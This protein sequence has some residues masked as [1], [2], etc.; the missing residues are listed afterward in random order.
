VKSTLVRA[1]N[2]VRWIFTPRIHAA[3]ITMTTNQRRPLD[4]SVHIHQNLAARSAV[5]PQFVHFAK[6]ELEKNVNQV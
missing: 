3:L 4:S 2:A 1:K 5:P 6:V